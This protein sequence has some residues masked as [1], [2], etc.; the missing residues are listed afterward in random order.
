M[1]GQS[2]KKYFSISGFF[3]KS[4]LNFRSDFYLF[5]NKS[6]IRAI[7]L[8]GLKAFPAFSYCKNLLPLIIFPLIFL[9]KSLFFFLKNS[10]SK[11]LE[12]FA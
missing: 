8:S 7:Y 3:D 6:F 10:T 9:R 11:V 1:L 12:R 5:A 2:R 4:L